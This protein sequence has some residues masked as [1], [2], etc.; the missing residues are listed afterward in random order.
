MAEVEGRVVLEEESCSQAL[1]WEV[2]AEK[3]GNGY[4]L[5]NIED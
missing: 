4:V 3:E 5:N 1:A 2:V